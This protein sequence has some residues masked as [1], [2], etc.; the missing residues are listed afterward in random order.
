MNIFRMTIY[1]IIINFKDFGY[2]FWTLCYPLLLC[3]LFMMTT[4]NMSN[5]ELEDINA[6]IENDHPLSEALASIEFINLE[7][8]TEDAAVEQMEA[9]EMAAYVHGDYELL[10][11]E[12]GFNQTVMEDV[13]TQMQS[14]VE[15][16]IPPQHFDMDAS[17]IDASSQDTQPETVLFYSLIAMIA[18]YGMFSSIE[19]ISTMQPNLSHMGARFAASPY[20]KGKL[21]AASVIGA[22]ALNLFSNTFIL[23]VIIIF[24]QINLFTELW[25]TIF[26]L[27]TANFTGVGFGL[28]L[29]LVPK[30]NAAA[31]TIIAIVLIIGLAALS[32][33]MGPPLK[34]VIDGNL[35]WI[36]TFNPVARLTDT[37]YRINFLGNFNDYWST[38]IFLAAL[39]LAF[40]TI[41]LVVLRR[42]QY[43]SI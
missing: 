23:I 33:L 10:V 1:L 26:L 21:L 19:F 7:T 34:Q 6:G 30:I 38:V 40:Y 32:G 39:A 3:A 28:I 22:M 43:D 31:K 17:F 13:L 5:T 2:W 11:T 24:Y 37:M 41:T 29:G 9:G 14:T 4:S 12:S 35:P 15:S 18:F 36:N 25:P 42:K 8:M 16:G 20:S 27:I